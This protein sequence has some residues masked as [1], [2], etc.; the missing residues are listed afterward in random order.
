M[1]TFDKHR[2]LDELRIETDKRGWKLNDT[3]YKESGHD[4]VS[5]IFSIN[6]INGYVLYNTFNGRFFGSTENGID[7]DSDDDQFDNDNW[8]NELLTVCYVEKIK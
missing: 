6:D 5:F 3:W 8:F 4:H 7:F 2:S 1:K